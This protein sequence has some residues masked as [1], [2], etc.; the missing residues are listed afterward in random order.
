MPQP[1][2]LEGVERVM[3]VLDAFTPEQ[4]E[5]RLTDLSL[6][7][8]LPKPQVLR[9]AT[10]LESGGYL[11]RDA[12]TKRYR[13]GVRLLQ[14]GS[15]VR[16]QSDLRRVARGTLESLA[17]DTLETVALIAADAQVAIC[18]DVIESPKGLRVFAAVGRRMPWN[19][20]AS[21]PVIL[22]YLPPSQQDRILGQDSFRRFTD[23]TITD[24]ARLRER[25]AEIRRSGYTVAI[26]DLD[27]SAGGVAAPIFNE[28]GVIAGAISVA[29]PMSRFESEDIAGLTE[30]TRAAA[31]RISRQLGYRGE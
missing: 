6:L 25:L 1:Y 12:L 21:A 7:L 5:L 3:D 30:L 28:T 13:L 16:G 22:A 9:I 17:A 31:S 29:A 27:D 4:P 20:G 18:I 24:A 8:D 26:N 19:A 11:Q 2:R 10:T 15:I 23:S 14:L